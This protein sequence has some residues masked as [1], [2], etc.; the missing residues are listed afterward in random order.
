ML[1]GTMHPINYYVANYSPPENMQKSEY[2]VYDLLANKWVVQPKRYDEIRDPQV[3][4]QGEIAYANLAS[5]A[6]LSHDKLESDRKF[7]YKF[8]WGIPRE[9]QQNILYKLMEKIR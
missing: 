4:F 2:A 6:N 3:E 7:V 5:R 9:L 1:P 8:G